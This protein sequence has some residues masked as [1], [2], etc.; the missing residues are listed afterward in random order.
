MVVRNIWLR[1]GVR[2]VYIYFEEFFDGFWFVFV[3][4]FF[5]MEIGVV[6]EDKYNCDSL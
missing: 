5:E 6:F 3:Y 2:F 1:F 4:D